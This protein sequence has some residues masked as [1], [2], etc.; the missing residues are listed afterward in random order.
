MPFT[1]LLAE[2][3]ERRQRALAMG[4]PERLA[5]RK[6]AGVLNARER[7]DYLLDPG[8]FN[9][10]GLFATSA[11]PEMRDR[12]P[13]DGKVCGFGR[14]QNRVIGLV[15]NDFT[16]L[17]ASSALVAQKKV[18]HVKE[19]ATTRGFPMVFLGETSGAR[20]PDRMGAAGRAMI[21]QDGAEYQRLRD[22]PWAS[23]LLGSCFGHSAWHAVLSDFVVM[24][25]GATLAV[26]SHRVSEKAIGRPITAEELGGW[27]MHMRVS[28]LVDAAVDTDEQALD[29][30][31]RFLSYMPSHRNEAPP[32]HPV[33]QGS[34][35]KCRN[36]LELLPTSR[37]QVYDVKKIID[38]IV[39]TGSMLELKPGFGRAI[40]TALTRIN[41]ATVGVIANNPIQKGGALDVDA[42]NKVT[43]FLVLCDSFNIPIVFLVDVPGFLIG[44]EGEM[45]GAPGRIINWVNA[46]SQ[47]TVP[48]ISIIMRK[49][50][51]KAY[52]N[53]GGGKNSDEVACWPSADLGFVDPGV[54]VNI[55]YGVKEEDDPVRF[56]KLADEIQQDNSVWGLAA[57]YET[58]AVIDP[59]DTRDYLIAT[60]DIHRM[61]LSNG[62]GQHRLRNWPTTF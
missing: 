41:G 54:G 5:K 25:K 21:G 33:P 49:S 59:R 36:I 28:G 10:S 39:D 4:G 17:G 47:V 42:C 15:S 35:D 53:M 38:A 6:Q 30:V 26:A 24:R 56:K 22:S 46:L 2:L 18:K 29:Q 62:V 32:M 23:A 44:L 45:R 31:K 58:Q 1:A 55:V 37:A 27:K 57:L 14:V 11:R 9:E 40:V 16:V 50:F 13:G 34:N 3:E 60:L 51:G 61:R 7:V 52:L 43:S 12:T 20:V 8:S 48:K 19:V